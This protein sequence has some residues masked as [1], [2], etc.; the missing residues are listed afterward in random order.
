[1][2]T[3]HE[4]P[5]DVLTDAYPEEEYWQDLLKVTGGLTDEKLARMTIVQTEQHVPWMKWHGVRFQA[6]LSGTL[7]LSRTNAFF[8]GG[9]KAL[10][11]AYYAAAQALG[12][13]VAYE[14][15]VVDLAIRDGR[16]VS[17]TVMRRGTRYE[18]R[19][20]AM[21]AASGASSRTSRGCARLGARQPTISSCVARRTTRDAC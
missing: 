12:V 5:L 20:K 11:N 1:M 4:V 16:F 14:T 2:R 10:V 18:I 9:G 6:P 8:L 21:V 13:E 7:Q 3:M 17:A 15:E 19:A